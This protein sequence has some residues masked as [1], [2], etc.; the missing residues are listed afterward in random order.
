VFSFHLPFEGSIPVAI[1]YTNGILPPNNPPANIPL[2]PNYI[3]S[4]DGLPCWQG[5]YPYAPQFTSP[6]CLA[7]QVQAIDNARMTEGNVRPLALPSDWGSLT[8]QEQIFVI[9]NLERVARGLTPFYGLSAQLDQVAQYAA[10]IPGQPL[11][12][13]EDPVLPNNFSFGAGTE[14]SYHGGS[15]GSI[16]A[17]LPIGPLLADYG[18]MYEDGWGGASDIQ[19]VDCT[20]PTA[21]GCWGHRDAIL[22]HYSGNTSLISQTA[23]GNITQLPSPEP[24]T[25][26]M[27]TGYWYYSPAGITNDT[28]IFVDV[29]GTLPPLAYTWAQ[30]V[31]AGAGG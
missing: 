26:L 11:G 31:A 17:E 3:G 5:S 1:V 13:W 19:N 4:V 27:G 16:G 6:A 22:G 18:W 10:D 14:I 7:A 24:V 8:P 20:V 29:V 9:I 28:A 2:S 15:G 25:M 21:I 12:A 30:A 23:S